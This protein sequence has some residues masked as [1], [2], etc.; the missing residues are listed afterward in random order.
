MF[1]LIPG[2]TRAG[3]TRTLDA[4]LVIIL[5]GLVYYAL[6]LRRSTAQPLANFFSWYVFFYL[7][8]VVVQVAVA[9]L[10]YSQSI[11]DGFIAARH[12]LYY[13]SFP[14]FL[15][16]LNDLQKVETFMKAFT[17]LAIVLI[18]ISLVNYSGF[19]MFYHQRAEGHG[20]RSGIVR[21]FIPAMSIMVMAALWEFWAYLRDNRRFS[22]HLASFMIV[23]G[24]II[25]RQTRG[26]I[27]AVTLTLVLMLIAKRRFKLLAG[28]AVLLVLGLGIQ[29]LV[30]SESILLNT[31]E[32][33]YS[34]V[35]QGEG[36]WST[37]M[38]QIQSSWNV[39]M[40]NFMT[41][42]GGLV[43]RQQEGGWAGWGDLLT[44]AFN[45]DLGYWTWLKFFGYPGIVFLLALVLVFY[46]YA[47][48]CGSHGERAYIGQFAAY[49]FTC[50]LISMVT[51]NYLTHPAGIVLLC[52][53]M[54]IVVRAAKAEETSLAEPEAEIP[55]ERKISPWNP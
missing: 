52:L 10:N 35:A 20:V 32:S 7:L 3:G 21:A 5:L 43:I 40:D 30:G 46:R 18:V 27:I 1:N 54:A 37:R 6:K 34:D 38:K 12:Q 31:F 14:V 50:I 2:N 29:M 45:A 49:H 42:S 22:I 39:F 28:G 47:L 53:T 41:G 36:T 8:L 17:G 23:Y 4:G 48:L 33:A 51:I 24:A 55:A 9:S 16:G 44:V 25:F 11:L 26:R 15:L 19:T 13:L